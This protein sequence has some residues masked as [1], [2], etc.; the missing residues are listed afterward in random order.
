MAETDPN[1]LNN[2]DRLIRINELRESAREI[3]CPEAWLIED[4]DEFAEAMGMD[5]DGQYVIDD[6]DAWDDDEEDDF[7]SDEE[8]FETW[9]T[10]RD[11]LLGKGVLLVPPENLDPPAL[12]RQL[13][14]LF[15]CLAE[16][17]TYIS[18]TNHLSD[19][20]LYEQLYYETLEEPLPLIESGGHCQASGFSFID[21]VGSGSEEDNEIYLMYYADESERQEWLAD[22]AI[23]HLPPRCQPPY[24]R[25]RHLPKPPGGF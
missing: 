11:Q 20:E 25:D 21:M 8:F 14:N 10:A 4:D 23:D 2:V 13:Q 16:I 6:L 15:A 22:G 1:R 19:R 3:G 24:D 18:N 9:T 12:A 5:E 17:H 7:D